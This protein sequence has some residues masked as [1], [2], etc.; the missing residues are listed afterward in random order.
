MSDQITRYVI[1][2]T[3]MVRRGKTPTLSISAFQQNNI[4]IFAFILKLQLRELLFTTFLRANTKVN[5]TFSGNRV[6]TRFFVTLLQWT[7]E[8]H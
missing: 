2:P 3:R 7:F 5:N 1:Y 8:C 6:Y 4:I